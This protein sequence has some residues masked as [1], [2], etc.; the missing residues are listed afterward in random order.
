MFLYLLFHGPGLIECCSKYRK[1]LLEK[2]LFT[3]LDPAIDPCLWGVRLALHVDVGRT[4]RS[5]WGLR[6]QSSR[7]GTEEAMPG[8]EDA[9]IAGRLGSMLVDTKAFL[10]ASDRGRSLEAAEAAA[11]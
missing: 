11:K 8:Q 5:G 10:S 9:S 3:S 4:R 7:C 1:S 2:R 6:S